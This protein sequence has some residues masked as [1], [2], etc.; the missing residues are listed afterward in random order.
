[1]SRIFRQVIVAVIF[2]SL[3]ATL[4]FGI[5]YAFIRVPAT[6]TDNKQNQDEQGI[7]CGGIC[8]A[9]CMEVVV[10]KDLEQQEVAFVPGGN[11]RYDVLVVL[12][13]ANSVIGASA[14]QYIFTLKDTSGQIVATRSGSGFILP[15]ETKSLIELNLETTGV[16]V[17]AT[18][19]ISAV[20]WEHFL[21]YQEKP[22]ISIYQKRYTVLPPGG[23]AFSEAYGVTSNES[24]YDF[25]SIVINVILRDAAGKAIAFNKTRQNTM[26][27]GES[28]DFTLVFPLPFPG[29]VEKV[30]ME[31]D[32]DAYHSE[33]FV[34]QYFPGGQR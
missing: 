16:P 3:N 31:V 7:D 26:I 28:R 34:Q 30:D 23:G 1:M 33:N 2:L 27:A 32:A 18:V 22:N 13:N 11:E 25:R 9:A 4:L 20:T 8:T 21:G 5:Y 10:G 6:C 12:H 24:P 29:A 17:T 19:A 14:F 15:E